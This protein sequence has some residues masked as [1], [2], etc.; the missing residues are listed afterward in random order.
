MQ[1]RRNFHANS[2]KPSVP[3]SI[4]NRYHPVVHG[5]IS[6]SQIVSGAIHSPSFGPV[7][8]RRLHSGLYEEL[9]TSALE[10]EI[11]IAPD[12]FDVVIVDEFHHAAAA[13]YERLLLRLKPKI[14][15]GLTATP[16]RAD[17]KSV[18][19]WFDGRIASESRLWDALDQ[20]LLCPFHYF[21]APGPQASSGPHVV[22][23]S[24]WPSSVD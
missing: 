8:M 14:L 3:A 22:C 13:S 21:G 19:A 16:E 2:G 20:G 24:G 12:G 1:K 15:L 6:V 7:M 17:G 11:D 5:A 9:L 23:R 4:H 18:L 10:A